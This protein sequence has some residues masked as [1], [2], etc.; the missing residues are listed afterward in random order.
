[1]EEREK[2]AGSGGDGGGE[3]KK[4]QRELAGERERER[5][6]EI[7]GNEEE[8]VRAFLGAFAK[9]L[10]GALSVIDLA[11][12]SLAVQ[13]GLVFAIESGLAVVKYVN[14]PAALAVEEPILTDIRLLL[15][16]A[17]DGSCSFVTR[18]CNKAVHTL[19]QLAISLVSDQYWL[20]EYPDC[21]ANIVLLY[22][23]TH[24]PSIRDDLQT[25][26]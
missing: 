12:E 24:E 6:I 2:T 1:M 17:G 14:N 26:H 3:G 15:H 5:E 18:D 11:A 8:E 22:V 4:R 19:P 13:E 21:I 16:E 25:F 10:V 9:K 7:G 20:E 23:R